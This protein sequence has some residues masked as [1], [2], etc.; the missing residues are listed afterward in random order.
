MLTEK[1]ADGSVKQA[2]DLSA[3]LDP[4]FVPSVVARQ[5][6]RRR[7]ALA[8]AGAA[9]R[10][11]GRPDPEPDAL[12]VPGAG[13]EGRGLRAAGRAMSGATMRRDGLAYTAG[14][15]VSFA[16]M[17]AVVDR[18]P[19]Q[20]RRGQLGLPVP[21]AGLL[22]ADRLSFLRGRPQPLRRLRD[23]RPPG[24][25]RPGPGRARRHD[26]RFLHRRAGGDRGHALHRAVHGGGPGF[27]PEPARA[28]DRGRA[29]GDGPWP[30]A[31][32]SR[33][34]DDA[35]AAAADAAARRRGWTGCASSSPSR[36]TPR[37]SG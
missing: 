10:A 36:C 2:F 21:V 20:R 25:R 23:R 26:R 16:A 6:G 33:A 22:A 13:D 5:R 35:G 12:R 32:L 30:R 31:P 1:T 29:A 24:R 27:C 7:A 11:A 3:K 15:L 8:R 9:V 18:D 17:A 34:L 19:R 28:R 14:V 4:A 37:P